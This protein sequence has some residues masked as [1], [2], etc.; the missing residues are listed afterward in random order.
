M[1][2]Q[3]MI[4]VFSG[5]E[6][7]LNTIILGIRRPFLKTKYPGKEFPFIFAVMKFLTGQSDI[8]DL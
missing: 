6:E 7:N 2:I 3:R 8:F 4:L 1:A 5:V